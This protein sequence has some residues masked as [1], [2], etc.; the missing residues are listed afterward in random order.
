MPQLLMSV[1]VSTHAPMH[2]FVVPPSLIG[3]TIEHVPFVH[4]HFPPPMIG[5]ASAP[6]QTVPHM[7]QLFVSS[8][9]STHMPMHVD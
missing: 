2:S 7:P 6:P 1:V 9:V 4:A 3:Q 8:F 5:P